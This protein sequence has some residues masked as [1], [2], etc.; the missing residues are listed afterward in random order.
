M[1]DILGGMF[2]LPIGLERSRENS[3]E[4]WPFL[5]PENLYVAN[6]RCAIYCL[7]S[8]LDPRKVWIPS[9]CC[10]SVQDAA[11]AARVSC[12][13]YSVDEHLH[14]SVDWVDALAPGD[15]V[16]LVSYFG[17]PIDAALAEMAREHGAV[18]VED[19]SQ[20][21]L[22]S[23]V[24]RYA[25]H[26]VYSP[27][28]VVPVPDGGILVSRCGPIPGGKSTDRGLSQ[29]QVTLLEASI[30]R[31]EYDIHG[32]DRRW[33]DLFQTARSCVP[34]GRIAMSDLAETL[35]ERHIDFGAVAAKRT[36]LFEL[37]NARLRPWGVFTKLT[38][39]TVP[40]G[41]PIRVQRRNYVRQQ[42][43]GYGIYP[44]VHW[45][46]DGIPLQFAASHRL[47]AEIMTLPCDQRCDE[48]QVVHMAEIVRELMSAG[49]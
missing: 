19:A 2:G 48:E 46:L 3:A 11:I 15:V 22:S 37:V 18:V 33:F 45:K 38:D 24:G 40:I 29:W 5:G 26:I 13:L 1:V 4:E 30:A 44:P 49:V 36:R 6:A 14:P 9:F 32:G 28:K 34:I 47:A 43:F 23:H 41:Y 17:F 10:P 39:G 16:I 12:A 25:D 20:S 35:M 21:L 42:L 27:R 31:R 8:A 7:L